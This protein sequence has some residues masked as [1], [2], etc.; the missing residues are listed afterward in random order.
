MRP[1]FF[2]LFFVLYT[3]PMFCEAEQLYWYVTFSGES[4]TPIQNIYA[5]DKTNGAFLGTVLA[6]NL[7]LNELRNMAIGPDG[8]LYVMNSHKTDS[9]VVEF[10]PINHDGLTRD[11]IENFVTPA[12][13][14]GL[15]HPY[16][17]AFNPLG[18]M[19]VSCQDTNIVLGFYGP[20]S[21]LAGNAR[22]ISP[23]LMANF[24]GGT[25]FPGTFI[26]AFTAAIPPATPVPSAQGGLTG[27]SSHS[28]RGIAFGPNHLLYVADE[29]TNKVR[30]YNATTGAF[31]MD[32]QDGGATISS[33]DQLLFNLNDGF[34]YIA[35]PG[36]NR[37]VQYHPQNNTFT[38]FIH[39]AAHLSSVSGIAFGED[40]NFY[41]ADRSS[42]SIYKYS[43]TGVFLGTFAGPFTD[44]PEGLYPVYTTFTIA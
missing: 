21:S 36:S 32:I 20:L 30:V 16:F 35:C 24:P 42:M 27:D 39:D 15:D 37:I 5:L 19:Y 34:I 6:D 31:I 17:V 10:G 14:A 41:A 18:D 29:L 3:F 8:N 13:S 44:S 9:R 33:P 7:G 40:G 26:P 38:T 4:A 1:I 22:P 11:F 2:F 25:F 28:V 43:D 12:N 23:F